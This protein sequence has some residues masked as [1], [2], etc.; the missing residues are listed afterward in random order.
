MELLG[1]FVYFGFMTQNTDL[2]NIS[3]SE[4]IEY[5]NYARKFFV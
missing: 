5:T 4:N 1:F 3:F 2:Q